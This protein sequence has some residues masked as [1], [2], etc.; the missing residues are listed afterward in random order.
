MYELFEAQVQRSPDA[1]ALVYEDER[2]SYAELNRRANR[3]AHALIER[4]VAPDEREAIWLPR[5][6]VMVVAVLAEL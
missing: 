1:V 3:L 4:G 2:L 5:S 6:P